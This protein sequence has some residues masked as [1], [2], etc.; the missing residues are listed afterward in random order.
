MKAK[1]IGSKTDNFVL[2][3]PSDAETTKLAPRQPKE[4][5]VGPWPIEFG[6]RIEEGCLSG[7][8][9]RIANSAEL[10]VPMGSNPIPS[11]SRFCW[12]AVTGGR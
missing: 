3:G 2:W 6:L 11:V 12:R 4:S 5:L 10:L 1:F 8:K 7:R 9:N